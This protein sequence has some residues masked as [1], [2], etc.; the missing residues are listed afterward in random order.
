M[1]I[2]AEG[3]NEAEIDKHCQPFCGEATHISDQEK[4]E[5]RIE[6]YS[7]RMTVLHP[8]KL[9]GVLYTPFDVPHVSYSPP[10]GKEGLQ[11]LYLAIHEGQ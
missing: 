9:P 11:N 5:G 6:T 4:N 8:D 3:M 2:L 1:D 10:A 7:L